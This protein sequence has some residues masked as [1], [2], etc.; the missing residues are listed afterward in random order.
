MNI[1]LSYAISERSVE[2]CELSYIQVE[3]TMKH[4]PLQHNVGLAGSQGWPDS[5]QEGGEDDGELEV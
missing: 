4:A 1:S 2:K 3:L 5:V